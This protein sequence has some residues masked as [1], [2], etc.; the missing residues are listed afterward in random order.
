MNRKIAIPADND[1]IL[2][3][4]FGH[5]KFFDI[6]ESVDNQILTHSRLVPP[7][8]EPGVLPKWIAAN[9]VSDVITGGIGER[10]V[11]VLEHFKINVHKGAPQKETVLLANSLLNQT[12]VLSEN[13]CNHDHHSHDHSH[14]HHHNHH[15]NH[16]HSNH[17]PD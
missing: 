13:N 15:N 9:G 14:E 16:H 3:T 2:D 7:P 10:A 17:L 5:C 8:H 12:L 1:G 6:Y 4:H 11:K